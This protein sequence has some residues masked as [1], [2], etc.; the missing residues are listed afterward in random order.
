M[1][2]DET[3]LAECVRR[4]HRASKRRAARLIRQR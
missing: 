3:T 2:R 4:V 1:E